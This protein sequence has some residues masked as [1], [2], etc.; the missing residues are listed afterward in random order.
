MNE[1]S[2]A[3]DELSHY[4]P[5]RVWPPVLLMLAIPVLRALPSLIENGPPN[6]WMAAAFGPVLCAILILLWW[7]LLSRASWKE[8][9]FGLLGIILSGAVG[10]FLVHSTMRGPAFVTLTT[11]MALVGFALGAIFFRNQLSFRRTVIAVLCALCGFGYSLALRNEGTWGDFKSE[12]LWRWNSSAEERM[13]AARENATQPNAESLA[14][15]AAIAS[16]VADTD[17]ANPQWS[18]FRGD[19]RSGRLSGVALEPWTSPPKE[20]WKIRVGPGWSSF[21][22]AGN[23]LF[24]QEQRGTNEVVV[25]YSADSGDEI[26]THNAESRFDDPLGGP[27]PR[28]TPTI[29]AGGVFAMG[30]EGW[31]MRLDPRTGDVVWKQDLREVADRKPPTWGFSSSPLVTQN[32]VIVHAGGSGDKGVLAFDVDSGELAWSVS[33]GDHSY[34]SPQLCMIGETESV[35]I[36]SNTGLLALDPASGEELLDYDWSINEYRALQPA[37]I[38]ADSVLIPTTGVGLRRVK[39]HRDDEGLTGEEVWSMRMKADFNDLVVHKGHAYG[40]DGS[41]FACVDLDTGKRIWKG[42]RYGKGQVLAIEQSDLLLIASEYGDVVLVETDPTGHSEVATFKAIEGKTWNHP[43]IVG[44][45]LYIRNAQE[46]AC[47]E[48]GQ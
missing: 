19:D 7:L 22:V 25:C 9:L 20:L 24:T 37:V 47:F 33:A 29:A 11:P 44:N 31:L 38:D 4:R 6:L 18:G 26:W 39:F 16:Q 28:A 35:V 3:A 13:L 15:L 32:K 42:G 14:A 48:F 23:L 2:R 12:Y 17:L 1:Q 8:R 30:A 40:F 34:S 41:I 27:G 10:G 36:L 21:A 45:R 46:A 5:L 43:V